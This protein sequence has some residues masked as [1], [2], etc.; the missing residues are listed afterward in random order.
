MDGLCMENLLYKKPTL[1]PQASLQ[2]VGSVESAVF[3]KK[4]VNN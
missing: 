3:Y 4:I 2:G 1:P